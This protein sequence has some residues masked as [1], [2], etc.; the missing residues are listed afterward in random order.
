[1]E[2]GSDPKSACS[3]FKLLPCSDEISRG[4][5]KKKKK[6]LRGNHLYTQTFVRNLLKCVFSDPLRHGSLVT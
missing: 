2:S 4:F 6:A 3:I 5:K 1:M